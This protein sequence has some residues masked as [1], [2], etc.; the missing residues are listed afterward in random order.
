MTDKILDKIWVT[1]TEIYSYEWT[2]R[3]G[4]IASPAWRKIL[5]NLNYEEMKKGFKE[6]TNP[7]T[8]YKDK[9]PTPIAFRELCKSVN[10]ERT[11]HQAYV[12]YKKEN[13]TWKPM[14]VESQ[15]KW[16]ELRKTMGL[17]EN[18][19]KSQNEMIVNVLEIKQKQFEE[20]NDDSQKEI[21]KREIIHLHTLKEIQ[22]EKKSAA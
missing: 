10:N 17:R 22:H 4:K 19:I 6:L 11:H 3:Y 7:G 15:I 13:H 16:N 9:P 1:M 12:D 20:S 2:N 8:L 21:I 5:I 14:S 18:K